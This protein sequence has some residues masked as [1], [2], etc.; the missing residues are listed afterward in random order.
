M[1]DNGREIA[2]LYSSES[3]TLSFDIEEGWHDI[4]VVICDMAGNK[5][6]I[7]ERTNIYVGYFWLW[8]IIA[9]VIVCAGAAVLAVVRGRGRR[10]RYNIF[11]SL[12]AAKVFTNSMITDAKLQRMQVSAKR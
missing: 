10:Y 4:G 5:N 12:K 1:Y 2:F 3:N 11:V 8:V 7:Q 9:G 6:I